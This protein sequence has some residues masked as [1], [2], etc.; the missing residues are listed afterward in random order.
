MQCMSDSTVL[1]AHL[2]LRSARARR[3]RDVGKVMELTFHLGEGH[4]GGLVVLE[5]F[6][7]STNLTDTK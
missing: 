5:L 4:L 1:V 6:G 2:P 7:R 3:K